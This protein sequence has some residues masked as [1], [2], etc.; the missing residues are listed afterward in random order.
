MVEK[1]ASTGFWPSLYDPFR[2]AGSRV[3]DWLAPESEASQDDK[4][5]RIVMELPGVSEDDV[6][7][8][9]DGGSGS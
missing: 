5:Y 6:Q 9:V 1:A 8:T 7:L 4:D 2:W 3:A